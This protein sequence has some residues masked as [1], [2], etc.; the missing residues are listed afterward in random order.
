APSAAPAFM[1]V[2]PIRFECTGC[3]NCCK[4]RG[5]VYFTGANIRGAEKILGI[6]GEEKKKFRRKLIQTKRN[7]LYIHMTNGRC[8]LLDDQDR[9]TIYESRPLQ[10]STYPFW[11]GFFQDEDDFSFLKN[12]CEGI[13]RRGGEVFSKLA[14]RRRTLKTDRDFKELQSGKDKFSL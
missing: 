1:E 12:E 6:K 4:G 14:I 8:M 5:E 2:R 13:G 9:C 10:C 3:G 7:G 11:P